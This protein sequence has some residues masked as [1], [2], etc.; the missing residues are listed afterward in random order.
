MPDISKCYG[1]DCPL[2]EKC[3]RYTCEPDE[4]HQAYQDFTDSLKQV[5]VK[6][7]GCFTLI[8]NE[9]NHFME[10]WD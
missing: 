6:K 4:L 1:K 5:E 7:S 2:K 8:K 3:Y 10:I 9:C